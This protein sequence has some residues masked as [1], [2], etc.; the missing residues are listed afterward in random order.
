MQRPVNVYKQD[1][2][3]V[4][5]AVSGEMMCSWDYYHAAFACLHVNQFVQTIRSYWTVP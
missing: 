1:L 5:S 2:P 3:F 4:S